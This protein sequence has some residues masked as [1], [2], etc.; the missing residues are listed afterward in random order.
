MVTDVGFYLWA[1]PDLPREWELENPEPRRADST[2]N[3]NRSPEV[4]GDGGHQFVSKSS[5]LVYRIV[6]VD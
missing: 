3:D 6:E 4:S 5:G 1:L 2:K